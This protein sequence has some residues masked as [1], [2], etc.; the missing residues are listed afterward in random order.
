MAKIKTSQVRRAR[1]YAK[2]NK[3]HLVWDGEEMEIA[4]TKNYTQEMLTYIGS[5]AEEVERWLKSLGY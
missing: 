2:D 4:P 5:T 1:Q 3:L